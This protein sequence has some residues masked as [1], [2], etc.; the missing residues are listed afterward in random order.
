MPGCPGRFGCKRRHFD[1]AVEVWPR[2]GVP[3]EVRGV[4]N[5]GQG[6]RAGNLPVVLFAPRRSRDR[7]TML[8]ASR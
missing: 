7:Q 5:A 1:Q 4:R 8:N 3:N 2:A 6:T